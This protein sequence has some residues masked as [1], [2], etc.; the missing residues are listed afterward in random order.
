MEIK[1]ALPRDLLSLKSVAK[2][3]FSS[4]ADSSLEQWFSFDVMQEILKKGLGICIKASDDNG[5]IIGMTFAQQESPINGHES[6]EKWVIVIAAVS[7]ENSGQGIGSA[8]LNS[9]EEEIRKTGATKLFVYTNK[10]DDKVINFYRKNGY[11]DAGWI[12]DYQYGKGN[13]A[14]FLLKHL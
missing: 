3:A 4:T 14:V 12:K 13:S 6:K 10:D 5:N 7:P 8:L 1:K 2:K 11:E 9:L